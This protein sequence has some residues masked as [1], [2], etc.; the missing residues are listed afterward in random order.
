MHQRAPAVILRFVEQPE[1]RVD[2]RGALV[3]DGLVEVVVLGLRRRRRRRLARRHPPLELTVRRAHLAEL[4]LDRREARLRLRLDVA[5]PR[6]HLGGALLGGAHGLAPHERV[7]PRLRPRG[8]VLGGAGRRA[9]P[10]PRR[11]AAA[12][13]R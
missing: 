9:A 2:L 4:V 8:R 7:R 13:R 1:A 11:A 12:P 3:L 6:A 5:E 10:A